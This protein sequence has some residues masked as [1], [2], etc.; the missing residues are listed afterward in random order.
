M[1]DVKG[2]AAHGCRTVP[3]AWGMRWAKALTLAYVALLILALLAVHMLVPALR[4]NMAY[5]YIQLGVI[6]PLLLSAAFTYNAA[7]REEHN[8]AGALMKVAMVMGAGFAALIRF[9]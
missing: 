2:D 6:A 8:R 9:L 1:A 5:W 4:G 7:T 3:I